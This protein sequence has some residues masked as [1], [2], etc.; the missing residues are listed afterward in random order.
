MSVLVV[1]SMAFD[2]VETPS[3]RRDNV[4]GGSGVFCSYAA[5][6]FSSVRLVGVVGEDWPDDFTKLLE[7]REIN[8]AGLKVEHGRK[9]FRWHGRYMPNMND[10]ETLDVQLNVFGD[11]DPV[12]PEEFRDT[13]FVFLANG[14]PRVQLKVLEQMTDPKIVIADTMD[15]WIREHREDL[16]TLMHKVTGLVLNDSEAILL[17]DDENL[18]RAGMAIRQM[19]PEFVVIK[20]GEHGAIFFSEDS[21]F[22]LPAFPTPQVVDPTGAGDTFAGGLIGV[23]SERDDVSAQS[24]KDA[25]AHG[26]IAASFNVEDF[27]LEKMK[28][29]G[30]HELDERMT[31]YREMLEL[32]M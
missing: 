10:R 22:A 30:R 7:A 1:G 9:T 29:I 2:S 15:L 8:L 14:V 21:V 18:V 5:S 17:A 25:I 26:I 13:R 4:I 28:R 19:G 27:S 32:S 6:Y 23:L 12:V 24:M 16:N 20:K 11:F 3:D 31:E